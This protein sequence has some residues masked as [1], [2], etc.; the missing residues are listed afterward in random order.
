LFFQ[1]DE[2]CEVS[3]GDK[4]GKYLKQLEVTLPRL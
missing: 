4:K 2:M 1:S 3:Y